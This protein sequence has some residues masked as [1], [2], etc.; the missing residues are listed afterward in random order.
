MSERTEHPDL[1]RDAM[2][3]AR[4]DEHIDGDTD[5]QDGN[6][7]HPPEV[8]SVDMN[9]LPALRDTDD[10]EGGLTAIVEKLESDRLELAAD[11][12]RRKMIAAAARELANT[13]WG[14]A[15]SEPMRKAV[16]RWADAAGLDPVR[17]VYIIGG[18]IYINAEYY[19]ER[20]AAR[21]DILETVEIQ[22]APLDR[23]KFD[24]VE[25]DG[26]LRQIQEQI[27]Q[28]RLRLQMVHKVPEIYNDPQFAATSA[29]VAIRVR[30]RDGRNVWG[31]GLA[32]SCGR[33]KKKAGGVEG[34]FRDPIG[35][36]SPMKTATTRAYRDAGRKIEPA[37]FKHGDM[38]LELDRVEEAIAEERAT[39]K[40]QIA[41]A[42]YEGITEERT[43]G[44]YVARGRYVE[45]APG[46]KFLPEIAHPPF[47]SE[48][49]DPYSDENPALAMGDGS[50]LATQGLGQ[51]PYGDA[52]PPPA[53]RRDF[54]RPTVDETC[55][56]GVSLSKMCLECEADEL[57]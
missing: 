23:R 43:Q 19:R 29:A 20:L 26:P 28:E 40:R 10:A 37:W 24:G 22:L 39:T 46:V 25:D 32:G 54:V 27:N 44:G 33:R 14:A 3:E 51:S 45:L 2:D 56:H 36:E 9:Q 47:P 21:P 17:H 53:E 4:D 57:P 34:G 7:E 31:L 6:D 49:R 1:I 5:E 18:R 42:G 8:E 52:T 13:Q 41:E 30:L 15:L 35:D 50:E 55:D 48:G 38:G 12:E 16:V 11:I